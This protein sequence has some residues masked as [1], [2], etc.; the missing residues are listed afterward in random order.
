MKGDLD[1][2]PNFHH[3]DIPTIAHVHVTVLAYHM[4]A[5]ILKKLRAAGIHYNRNTIR[6]ILEPAQCKSNNHY[7]H[8]EWTCN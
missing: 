5:R 3:D 6:N 2:R 7:E 4:P 8:R 1:L